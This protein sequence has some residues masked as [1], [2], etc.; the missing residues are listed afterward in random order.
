MLI[1]VVCGTFFKDENIVRNF[2]MKMTTLTIP[3]L[4]KF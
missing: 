2:T 3:V 1:V 4:F